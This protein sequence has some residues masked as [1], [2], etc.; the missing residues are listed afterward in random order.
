MEAIFS[1]V[2]FFNKRV[3]N[4]NVRGILDEDN[5]KIYFER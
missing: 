2:F 1:K 4:I 3:I 5:K